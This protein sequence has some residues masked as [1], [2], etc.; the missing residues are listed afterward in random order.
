MAKYNTDP[1]GTPMPP[2][3]EEKKRKEVQ[4]KVRDD[5]KDSEEKARKSVENDASGKRKK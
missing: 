3:K 4:Q 5:F 2:D 1:A